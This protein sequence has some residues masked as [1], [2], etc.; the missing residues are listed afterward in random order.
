MTGFASWVD[1]ETAA[2]RDG[3]AR[4]LLEALSGRWCEEAD[5]AAVEALA[6][7]SRV[8][9]ELRRKLAAAG[10]HAPA[11]ARGL[12]PALEARA[13]ADGHANALKAAAVRE[14][15]EG[16]AA[17]GFEAVAL[18]GFHLAYGV[19]ADPADRP[20]G[21]VDLLVRR[22]DLGAAE[23]VLRALGFEEGPAQA[24]PGAMERSFLRTLAHGVEL[25]VDLHWTLMG[26][27]S[28]VREMR[29]DDEGMF[30]RSTPAFPGLRFPSPEDALVLAAVNL[31]RHGFRPLG[32]ILDFRELL[33][34][35]DPG[36]LA[37][38]AAETR[39]SAA[40]SA[41][42]ALAA[43]W[44]GAEVPEG[45]ARALALPRWQ[46]ALF[47]RLL[48]PE[49]LADPRGNDGVIA[50]YFLKILAQDG[51][52][53]VARTVAGVPGAVARRMAGGQARS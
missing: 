39:T 4:A 33:R 43:A 42:L 13:L 25:D 12:R 36:V 7:T 23:D 52:R 10:T 30:A 31:V 41:G 45:L 48:R 22:R 20:F 17:R 34:R 44:F 35:A 19:Y 53:G 49:A 32:N 11:W 47:R 46:R 15:G 16:F 14:A 38:R 2:V 24:G 29:P 21:D 28:L 50:R 18:K 26:A 40:L 37:A 1:R 51:L 9:G 8:A 3:A 27:L 5:P 6:V